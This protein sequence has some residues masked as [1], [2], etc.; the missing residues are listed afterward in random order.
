MLGVLWRVHVLECYKGLSII[1][2]L[3]ILLKGHWY[4]LVVLHVSESPPD[5]YPAVYDMLTLQVPATFIK[6]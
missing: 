3:N 6:M 5:A 2:S 4:P 1:Y